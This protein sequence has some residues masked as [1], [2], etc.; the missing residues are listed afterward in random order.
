[1]HSRNP[2]GYAVKHSLHVNT[3]WFAIIAWT[4]VAVGAG[5]WALG[6]FATANSALPPMAS[7]SPA[8]HPD[9]SLSR[10]LGPAVAPAAESVLPAERFRLVGVVAP[11]SVGQKVSAN[12]SGGIALISV[13][14]GPPIAFR[15]GETVSGDTVLQGVTP[16]GA[17]L[18]ARGASEAISLHMTTPP[19][20][21]IAS[22]TA[23]M[24]FG[25][26]P[27][28]SQD[29]VDGGRSMHSWATPQDASEEPKAEIVPQ[30]MGDGRWTR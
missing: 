16:S 22:A 4:A 10:A 17:T 14:D 6:L 28:Q 3:R 2:T 13:N 1:M 20:P 26:L 7:V 27:T 19:T 18:V 29:V 25:T 5:A 23:S 9:G 11:G 15:V 30:D 21:A 12:E 8:R 24:T